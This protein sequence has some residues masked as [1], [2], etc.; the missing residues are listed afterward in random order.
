[1]GLITYTPIHSVGHVGPIDLNESLAAMQRIEMPEIHNTP[2]P[3][4]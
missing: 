1:M 2:W 4:L 3:M